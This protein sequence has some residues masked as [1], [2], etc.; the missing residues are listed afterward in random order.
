MS[1]YFL[2]V[3]QWHPR[4]ARVPYGSPDRAIANLTQLHFPVSNYSISPRQKQCPKVQSNDEGGNA[5]DL[6]T[7]PLQ[8]KQHN[9]FRKIYRSGTLQMRSPTIQ[10]N[11]R[12]IAIASIPSNFG[13]YGNPYLVMGRKP[14][15]NLLKN[16]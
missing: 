7:R 8:S 13:W 1:Q 6:R 10:V 9:F 12:R 15:S 11:C 14:A 4:V 3:A 5:P 2:D 16:S